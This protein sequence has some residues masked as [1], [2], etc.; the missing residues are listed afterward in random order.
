LIITT[1]PDFDFISVAHQLKDALCASAVYLNVY[2]G[3]S[4]MATNRLLK[5][6]NEAVSLMFDLGRAFE[7]TPSVFESFTPATLLAPEDSRTAISHLGIDPIIRGTLCCPTY[8]SLYPP[9]AM[10]CMKKVSN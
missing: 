3:I 4:R 8:L 9:D 7:R 10:T 1:A 6:Q 2:S 5:A